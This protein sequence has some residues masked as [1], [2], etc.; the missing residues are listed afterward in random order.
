MEEIRDV[1]LGTFHAK[2]LHL[3]DITINDMKTESGGFLRVFFE[4]IDFV[5]Q[6]TFSI[7][8]DIP[9]GKYEA[10]AIKWKEYSITSL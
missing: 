2:G 8:S 6:R 7:W 10:G 1:F 3:F 5:S 9:I 4:I